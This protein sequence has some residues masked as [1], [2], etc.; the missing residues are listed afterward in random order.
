M[1][2]H[3]KHHRSSTVA[4]TLPPNVVA[5]DLLLKGHTPKH[6]EI[7]THHPLAGA[8]LA[9]LGDKT[10]TKRQAVKFLTTYPQYREGAKAA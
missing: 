8:F 9:F 4:P 7:N 2:V 6:G 3:P 5:S 1:S 10:P